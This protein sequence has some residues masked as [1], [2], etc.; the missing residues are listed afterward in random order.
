MSSAPA[1]GVRA[2]AADARFTH[3]QKNN[4]ATHLLFGQVDEHGLIALL[5]VDLLQGVA[6]RFDIFQCAAFTE[7]R[8]HGALDVQRRQDGIAPHDVFTNRYRRHRCLALRHGLCF[9]RR[10]C[11]RHACRQHQQAKR[12]PARQPMQPVQ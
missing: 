1:A 5:L 3:L 10:L 11:L 6:R 12:H 7:E 9:P 8:I 2:D 4:A